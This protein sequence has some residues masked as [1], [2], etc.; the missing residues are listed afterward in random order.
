MCSRKTIWFIIIVLLSV[1]INLPNSAKASIPTDP[2]TVL[3]TYGQE[4]LTLRQILWINPTIASD[5]PMIKK[6]ADY[7]LD[8]HMLYEEAAR[9]KLDEDLRVQFLADMSAKKVFAGELINSIRDTVSVDANAVAKYYEDN[10]ENDASLKTPLYL[11]FS[12]IKTNTLAEAQDIRKRIEEGEDINKLAKELSIAKD[13]EKGGKAAKFQENTIRT[14]FN[15][16]FLDALN[17]ASEGDVIGPIKVKEDKYEVAQ[18]QG[19]RNS[20]LKPFEEVEKT[21]R[22][23][24]EAEAKQEAVKELFDSLKEKAKSKVKK[25]SILKEMEESVETYDKEN[26]K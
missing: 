5:A 13:G 15:D 26:K 9:R 25:M 3:M 22:S 4:Q 23:R 16:E 18:H 19:R 20:K 7:W 1:V 14:R 12:H 10:K 17:K 2:N 21:I 11:S 8:S 24:L 6:I